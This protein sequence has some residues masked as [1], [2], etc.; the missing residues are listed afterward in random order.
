[1]KEGISIQNHS[2]S[3]GFLAY[4]RLERGLSGNTL[5]AYHQDLKKFQDYLGE[6]ENPKSLVEVNPEDIQKFIQ[7][8]GEEKMN[9]RSQSRIISGLKSFF[10]Y[11][12]L[13]NLRVSSPME[14]ISSPK[15]GR[16]LPDTLS[17]EEI[18]ALMD[19]IDLSKPDGIRNKAIIETLYGSGLRVTELVNLKFSD[20]VWEIRFLKILGKGNKERLVPMSSSSYKYIHLYQ[21][22]WRNHLTIQSGNQ[23]FVFLNRR[24]TKLSRVMIFQIIKELAI[25]AGIKKSISPHTFRHSFASH[26]IEGGADLRAVQEMLGHESILTTEIYTHLDR[27]F[28]RQTLNQYHPRS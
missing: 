12:I 10:H 3:K 27:D 7:A 9:P 17:V 14:L 4:L 16:E 18:N 1:M 6:M 5:Q 22:N 25:K 11:L 8:I 23:D 20:I 26:L 21:E 24:G 2:L 28:L 15:I 19:Q 13:E